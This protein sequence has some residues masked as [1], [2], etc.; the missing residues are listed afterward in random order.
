[1][2][3][4]VLTPR[5]L[6][7]V[8]GV[9]AQ[10]QVVVLDVLRATS[11]MVAGLNAGAREVRLFDSLDAARDAR[12]SW[13]GAGPVVLAGESAC[14]KP[15][16]FDLGNSPREHVTEKVGGA[17]VL[18]ATTNGTRAAVR[19][20]GARRMFAGCLLN[21]AATAGALVPGVEAGPTILVC[22]GTNGG[23]AL[24]DVIGAGAILFAMMQTTYR[25]DL[26]FTDSAWLAYHT[27][28][29]K[30]DVEAI[31]QHCGWVREKAGVLESGEL[32]EDLDFYARLDETIV[33]GIK[34]EPLRAVRV[35]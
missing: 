17:T 10:S 25:T 18:L 23:L 21:A 7:R 28:A 34:T 15:G 2:I 20:N 14:L 3:D 35:E 4:V 31:W 33:V 32:E 26:G 6:C 19:A 9:L 22:A 8:E 12:R 24:E 16:N 29:W 1:M 13:S 11:T 30:C 5:D 27:V